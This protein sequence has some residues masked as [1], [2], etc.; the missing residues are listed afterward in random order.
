MIT[1]TRNATLSDLASMLQ[2]L[3]TRKIDVVT[4]ASVLSFRE[5]MLQL[6]GVPPILENDGVTDPNGDYLPTEVFDEGLAGRL[7]I[8]LAYL[9]RLR[10]ERPDLYDANANGWLAGRRALTR[11]NA[12][13]E[14]VQVRPG[15]A[16]DSRSFMVRAYR[17]DDGHGIA[18][19]LLSNSYAVMDNLDALTA[20]LDGIRQAG[21]NVTVDRCDLTDR[22]M[23]VRISSPDIVTEATELLRGYRNPFNDPTLEAQRQ[24]L[25]ERFEAGQRHVEQ[26]SP[27]GHVMFRD[28]DAPIVSAGLVLANSETGSGAW[29]L[30]P[31]IVVLACTNGMMQTKDAFR[32]VHLGSRLEDGMINWSADTQRKNVELVTAKTRDAV[33][34]FLTPE[35]LTRAVA[36]LEETATMPLAKPAEAIQVIGKKLAFSDTH[37]AGILD[38]FIAGG[39]T[40]AGGV[41][42]AVTSYSQTVP[43]ADMAW[44]L[45]SKA[46]SAMELA[47]AAR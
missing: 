45:D 3:H 46:V 44:E 31:Q 17:G 21:V 34:S 6:R 9:R 18:R 36:R 16:P 14:H 42:Q 35:Y 23:Y 19:G 8:P 7:G 12:D 4:P 40:T 30:T 1:T 41:M 27:R 32:A 10:A 28:N 33:A 2:D 37:I 29:T 47:V 22:R 5:G 25:V 26:G 13:G 24:H 20:T 38:H 15:I 11:V 39:Q 43:D